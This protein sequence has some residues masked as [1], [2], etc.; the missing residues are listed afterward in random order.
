MGAGVGVEQEKILLARCR[1]QKR[2]AFWQIAKVATA[3]YSG[4]EKQTAAQLKA[5]IKTVCNV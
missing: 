2:L 3:V 5:T 1:V 4:R